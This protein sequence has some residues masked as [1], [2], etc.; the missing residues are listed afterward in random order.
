MSRGERCYVRAWQFSSAN[1]SNTGGGRTSRRGP[2]GR[3]LRMGL[4][5]VRT[6]AIEHVE[7]LRQ[8]PFH[9]V[10]ERIIA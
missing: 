7:R 2:R 10:V 1:G 9:S 3:L 5:N 8:I 4:K 6:E